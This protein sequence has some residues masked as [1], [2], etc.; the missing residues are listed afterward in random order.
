[1]K[2][3]LITFLFILTLTGK[4]QHV[5]E[6]VSGFTAFGS[7]D[8]FRQRTLDGAGSYNGQG[9][10]AFG[11]SYA[12]E[13]NTHLALETG[14]V[15]THYRFTST[16]GVNPGLDLRPIPFTFSM[17][18]LPVSFRYTFLKY[19]FTNMGLSLNMTGGGKAESSLGMDLGLGAAITLKQKVRLFVSPYVHNMIDVRFMGNRDSDHL[20]ETGWKIGA[21]YRF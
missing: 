10:N 11:I 15:Y 2:Y 16:P 8:L 21:G 13:K 3:C 6:C 14:L 7:D 19:F 1:M 9:Y 12:W 20:M 4:S 5:T 18:T 17:V